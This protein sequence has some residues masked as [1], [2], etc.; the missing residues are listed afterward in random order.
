MLLTNPFEVQE[1]IA[2]VELIARRRPI[3]TKATR[4]R[5]A[6]GCRANL[7]AIA[8]AACELR[9]T[10]KD[11]PWDSVDA[12][13]LETLAEASSFTPTRWEAQRIHRISN[14]A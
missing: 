1:D 9:A 11:R 12:I 7:W 6:T 3:G 14:A 4:P 2:L 10:E 5:P 13:Y 8:L